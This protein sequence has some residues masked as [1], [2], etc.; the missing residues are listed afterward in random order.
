[1]K[2]FLYFE[3]SSIG[4]ELFLSTIIACL[5]VGG[6]TENGRREGYDTAKVKVHTGC[7]CVYL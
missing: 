7:S 2:T 4:S 5:R 6:R 3:R 1:M